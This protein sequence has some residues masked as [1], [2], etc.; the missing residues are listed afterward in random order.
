MPKISQ[1][2]EVRVRPKF[3][4]YRKSLLNL[5]KLLV[6][7]YQKGSS[8]WETGNL[9]LIYKKAFIWLKKR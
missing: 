4:F 5:L 6:Y 7:C 2:D 9:Q 1:I 8:N 3:E